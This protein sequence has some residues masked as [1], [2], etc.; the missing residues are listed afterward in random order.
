[1]KVDTLCGVS[2]H[3]KPPPAEASTSDGDA[4]LR[5][6]PERRY[7]ALMAAVVAHGTNLGI[8]AMA[9]STEDLTVRV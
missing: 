9:D 6:T 8:A 7:S 2:Q 3:V 1:M 4:L 5:L